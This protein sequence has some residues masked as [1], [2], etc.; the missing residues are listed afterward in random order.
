MTVVLPNNT[1]ISSVS[2]TSSSLD[3]HPY[4]INVFA[5]SQ[6]HHSLESVAT[7]TNDING[8]V[9]LDKF[10]A[11]IQNEKG[12]VINYTPKEPADRI[13]TFDRDAALPD[14][15]SAVVRHDLNAD[16]V[17]YAHTSFNSPP[18]STFSHALKCGYLRTYPH[19]TYDMFQKNMPQSIATAKGHLDQSR[20]N[21]RSTKH[22][23]I[24]PPPAT[25]A[26]VPLDSTDVSAHAALIMVIPVKSQDT[27]YTDL[28]G[29]FPVESFMRNN[30]VMLSY[31]RG[32]VHTEAMK[33][34]SSASLVAAYAAT[35]AYYS[36]LNQT[37]RYQRLDNET[38]AAVDTYL[39]DIAKVVIICAA[40]QQAHQHCRAHYSFVEKSFHL[41]S[42]FAGFS[43]PTPML[44]LSSCPD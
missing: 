44:G 15:A 10:G 9:T 35:F 39:R 7:F 19:L 42:A 26:D 36:R 27:N 43:L 17:A 37:P 24:I 11:T 40:K 13:W 16:F 8:S 22:R 29:K 32:Y 3:V 28:K 2:T 23:T 18:N 33:D 30:Y 25:T 14:S 38:S 5:N 21:H 20:K 34:R 4:D 12:I 6:L 31:Y 1:T 41:W